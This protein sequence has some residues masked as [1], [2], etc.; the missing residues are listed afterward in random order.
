[1]KITRNAVIPSGPNGS[2][3][4]LADEQPN[5]DPAPLS[6]EQARLWRASHQTVAPWRIVIWQVV[7]GVVSALV[8][9][10]FWGAGAAVSAAY[11]ALSVVRPSALMVWGVLRPRW[12][13]SATSVVRRF[14][15]WELVKLGLTVAM[16][17]MAPRWIG[18]VN[19]LALLAGF[20]V[21]MKAFGV[22]AWLYAKRSKRTASN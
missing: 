12:S 22:A 16:L 11:G 2:D 20:L 5:A 18:S 14:A 21:T 15:V 10:W 1:M 3:G 9:A 17:V 13:D 7:T 4:D 19:W 8:V 6:A